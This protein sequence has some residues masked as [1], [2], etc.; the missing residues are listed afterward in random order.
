MKVKWWTIKSF[1]TLKMIHWVSDVF[2]LDMRGVMLLPPPPQS[3]RSC[4]KVG[5]KSVILQ[6]ISTGHSGQNA[7]S[8]ELLGTS[9]HWGTLFEDTA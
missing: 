6:E 5:Q 2:T 7:P 4:K 3:V 9:L 1:H 8:G